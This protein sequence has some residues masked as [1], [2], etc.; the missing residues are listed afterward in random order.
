[1]VP[2][3]D[4]DAFRRDPGSIPEACVDGVAGQAASGRAPNVTVFA[5]DFSAPVSWRAS[6][7]VER[8]LATDLTATVSTTHNLGL[9]QYS[10][11]DLNL[12][13]TPRFTLAAEDDRPVFMDA[14]AIIVGTGNVGMMNS[15]THRELGQVLEIRSGLRSWSSQWTASLRWAKRNRHSVT[16]SYAFAPASDQSSFSCCSAQQGFNSPTTAGFPDRFEWARSTY[17]R[18][19]TLSAVAS[20]DV[21]PWANLRLNGRATSG[22]PFTPLV[23][24]DINGDGARNDRAFIFDPASTP[25]SAVAAGMQRILDAAPP[26]ISECLRRQL[27]RIADRNSCLGV[28]T[29]S[30]ELRANLTPQLPGTL[31]KRV[32]ASIAS[33]NLLAGI[34]QMIHPPGSLRGWGQRSS[35]DPTLLYSRGFDPET[36]TFVYEVNERFGNARQGRVV[37][38]SPFQ[39]Q[40]EARVAL[41]PTARPQPRPQTPPSQPGQAASAAGPEALD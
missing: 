11:A 33:Q 6:L 18:R 31:G 20:W 39:L 10:V 9:N 22:A 32:T 24:N 16:A 1:M 15:R 23:G 25:D 27:G 12:D 38:G 5:R 14:E 30:L 26:R 28:R 17:E 34:D 29:T 2:T 3:P 36:R 35:P 37:V 40:L 19:H 41:G 7:E 8:T 21:R 4:W 13:D